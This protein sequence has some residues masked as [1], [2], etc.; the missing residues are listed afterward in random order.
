MPRYPTIVVNQFRIIGGEW[1]GRRLQFPDLAELRPSPDRVRETLFN[2]LAPVIDG[3]RCL[4]L[5][6]G[7]GALGLEALSRGAAESVF[8]D[9]ERDA[10]R[11]IDAHLDKLRCARGRTVH[12]ESVGFLRGPATPFDVV[13]L[14]PPFHRELLSPACAQL[15]AG[16]WVKPGGYVYLEAESELKAPQLPDGWMLH[17]SAKAGRVGYHLATIA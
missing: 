3:A 12:A 6:C 17:R 14:D 8:V 15:A 4:D 11:M 5:Y 10:I 1:R 13:F 2:W 16:G 7:S 9:K